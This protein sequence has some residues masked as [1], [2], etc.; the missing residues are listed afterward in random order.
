MTATHHVPDDLLL[1]YVSGA[2][3]EAS[4]VLVATHLAL[5]PQCRR[6][7]ARIEAIG[8]AVFESLAPAHVSAG[9]LD[10]ALTRLD[11][12]RRPPAAPSPALA[13]EGDILIPQPLRGYLPDVLAALP[14]RRVARGVT[15][16]HLPIGGRGRVVAS[17]LRVAPERAMPRHTHRGQELLL[18]LDGGF[19]DETGRYRRGDVAVCDDEIEHRPVADPGGECLC[20]VAMDAPVRLT[21]RWMR[22]LNPF[23][24]R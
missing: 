21:G 17:L 13:P 14:W 23:L 9:A 22:L 10:R 8:G 3:P 12:E 19:A 15:E 5:C 16:A 24:R 1:D 11:D 18:V 4:S 20:L 6:A 2:A 7:S